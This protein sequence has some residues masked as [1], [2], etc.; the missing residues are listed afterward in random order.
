MLEFIA[1][2]NDLEDHLRD[3]IA[4]AKRIREGLGTGPLAPVGRASVAWAALGDMIEDAERLLQGA[5]RTAPLC[6][7][8]DGFPGM[9]HATDCQRREALPD[10]EAW[11]A[12][13]VEQIVSP[14]Q[15]KIEELSTAEHKLLMRAL[16]TLGDLYVAWDPDPD[17][18]WPEWTQQ[19]GEASRL[20]MIE[21]PCQACRASYRDR[22]Q[23]CTVHRIDWTARLPEA[24]T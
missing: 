8:A 4:Q 17:R 12:K 6:C 22:A 2:M 1:R 15:A 7:A 20:A 13:T 23:A 19:M 24:G 16:T 10:E 3:M 5:A 21:H 18:E 9:K 11:I 14:I